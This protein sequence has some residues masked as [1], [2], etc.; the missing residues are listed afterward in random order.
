MQGKNKGEL[1]FEL[2]F[3]K[4][5]S[6]LLRARQRETVPELGKVLGDLCLWAVVNQLPANRGAKD[7]LC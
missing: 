7:G 2:L 4:P 5:G 1:D 6:T 3:F